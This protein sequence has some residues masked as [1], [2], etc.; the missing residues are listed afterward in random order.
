MSQPS[1]LQA[2]AGVDP[3]ETGL[4]KRVLIINDQQTVLIFLHE[5]LGELGFEVCS[6]MTGSEG[7][8]LLQKFAFEGIIL[9]L[10]MPRTDGISMLER[11][12]TLSHAVPIIVM[13]GD[14]TRSAMIKAVEAGAKDYILKPITHEILKFKCLRLFT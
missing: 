9:D 6:A 2:A 8:S 11:L 14:P 7:M 5:I 3:D 4:G 1:V 12:Q 13:S 10:D